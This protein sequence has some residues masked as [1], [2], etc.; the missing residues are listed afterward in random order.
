MRHRRHVAL[1]NAEIDAKKVDHVYGRY[2]I[3]RFLRQSEVINKLMR[4]QTEFVPGV[5]PEYITSREGLVE[6]C[7]IYSRVIIC[8]D[9]ITITYFLSIDCLRELLRRYTV[10]VLARIE[11]AYAEALERG[12][13]SV[14]P[15]SDWYPERK[16]FRQARKQQVPMCPGCGQPSPGG[17]RELWGPPTCKLCYALFGNMDD[18]GIMSAEQMSWPAYSRNRS[19][20]KIHNGLRQIAKHI[21]GLFPEARANGWL[22]GPPGDLD[23]LEERTRLFEQMVESGQYFDA[24]L[25]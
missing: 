20:R 18:G 12:W 16:A 8:P 6:V 9:P 11:M 2:C 21:E 24:I 19:I 13:L 23:S 1:E 14:N 22:F 25:R 10:L 15:K 5:F 4:L 7:E 3:H 17:S